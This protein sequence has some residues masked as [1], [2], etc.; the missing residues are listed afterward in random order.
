MDHRARYPPHWNAHKVPEHYTRTTLKETRKAEAKGAGLVNGENWA[1][2]CE[3][4]EDCVQC[5]SACG[6]A[7]AAAAEPRDAA[8][9]LS[10]ASQ[11]G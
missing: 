2:R 11:W 6:G 8:A 9:Q 4:A 7:R 5:I 1:A 10:G 3:P